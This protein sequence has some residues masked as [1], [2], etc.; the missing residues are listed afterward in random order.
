MFPNSSIIQPLYI[1]ILR[2]TGD[3]EN[4]S[5]IIQNVSEDIQNKNPNYLL[6][7]A[8][9]LFDA[10]NIPEAKKLFQKLSDLPEWPD[11]VTESE[12][13]LKRIE[14]LETASG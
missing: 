12:S 1:Q 7:K 11:I 9:L 13:Y 5:A 14:S 2:L 3:R 4:A 10:G 8:I 6:E